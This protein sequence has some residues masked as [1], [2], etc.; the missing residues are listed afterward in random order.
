MSDVFPD[1][2]SGYGWNTSLEEDFTPYRT[3]GLTPAR[4]VR[5]DRGR[6]EVVTGEGAL[7]ADSR[8]VTAP[9]TGDWAAVRGDRIE[10]LLPRRTAIVRA[11]AARTSRGQVLAANVDT[12]VVTVPLADAISS[13]RLERLL[14]LAWESGA[15][16][17]IALTKADLSPD[18]QADRAEA[19][20]LAPGVEVF[21]VAAP[22]GEG[23]D[24]LRAAL[25][26]TVA[27][28]GTSGAGK[29]TLGN[30]LLGSAVLRTGTVSTAQHGKGRHT[31]VSRELVPLPGPGGGTLIDTPG[32]RGVGLHEAGAGLQQAF[33]EI[34]ELAR[35]CRFADCAHD[36]EPG[37]AIQRA[38]EDGELPERRLASYRKLEREG[39]RAAARHDDRLRAVLH[40]ETINRQKAISRH[41]RSVY[42]KDGGRQK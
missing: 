16:P 4:I 18:P 9:C 29:S 32:L 2:L 36:S 20:S 23:M 15:R 11:E 13:D 39:R 10:A 38:I 5:V 28:L 27:L 40:K 26:G 19:E 17:V 35:A 7:H 14:A 34:E 25:S 21:P 8:A 6:C 37:C 31:T 42:G 1:V 22:S 30:A 33:A 12:I 41:L 3:E 24:A